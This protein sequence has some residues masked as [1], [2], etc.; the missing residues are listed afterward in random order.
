[1]MDILPNALPYIK[2][3]RMRALAVTSFE[4][5]PD[6]PETPTV[7][8]AGISG[9]EA[10]NWYGVLA[11][12]GTPPAIVSKL[13]SAISTAIAEPDVSARL[14]GQGYVVKRMTPEAFG[15][16][17]DKDLVNWDRAIKVSGTK[18]D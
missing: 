4:R 16:L 8:Q 6:L 2:A 7:A 3:G 1:M 5:A 11:P 10:L 18:P 9:F 14:T 12:A 15:A 17:I 13:N